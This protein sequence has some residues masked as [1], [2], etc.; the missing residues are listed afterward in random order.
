MHTAR[1]F[2][3][4]LA[5]ILTHPSI[6]GLPPRWRKPIWP[7]ETESVDIRS[8]RGL[9]FRVRASP[10]RAEFDSLLG[11]ECDL[12]LRHDP[13]SGPAGGF[14]VLRPQL[15]LLLQGWRETRA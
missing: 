5:A 9:L 3:S 12:E 2:W 7:H 11:P 10:I 1:R 15:H 14:R 4:A 6:D 8:R 13:G